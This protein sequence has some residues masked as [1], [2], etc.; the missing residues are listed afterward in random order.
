ML[1][2]FVVFFTEGKI[3]HKVNEKSFKIIQFVDNA[4]KHKGYITFLP[5]NYSI[6]LLWLLRKIKKKKKLNRT[7]L[8]NL[9]HS[10]LL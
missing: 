2:L 9:V 8:F 1:G 10:L 3:I 5:T 7:Q 4:V 6:L